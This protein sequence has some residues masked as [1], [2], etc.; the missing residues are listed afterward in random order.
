VDL[1]V[2]VAALLAELVALVIPPAH[3]QHKEVT[4]EREV[5][6]LLVT[7]GAAV[8]AQAQQVELGIHQ[9]LVLVMAAQEQHQVYLVLP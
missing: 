5:K 4:E 1:A 9:Q 2:V 7:K 3:H 8:A 6:V